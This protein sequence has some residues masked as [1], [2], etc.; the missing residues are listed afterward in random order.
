MVAVRRTVVWFNE[1][2]RSLNLQYC[3]RNSL[4]PIDELINVDTDTSIVRFY[5]GDN[6]RD[7]AL[8]PP[9]VW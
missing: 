5:T 7:V 4:A 6:L 1:V 2:D 9:G 8:N 3:K